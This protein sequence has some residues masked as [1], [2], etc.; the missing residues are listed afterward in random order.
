MKVSPENEDEDVEHGQTPSFRSKTGE[1]RD[2]KISKMSVLTINV[3]S[4]GK[5]GDSETQEE[6]K[7]NEGPKPRL[8][9]I[10]ELT[11]ETANALS[12]QLFA[13]SLLMKLMWFL[14]YSA[15]IYVYILQTM[16][17]L[18]DYN[19][20]PV[21]VS[22]YLRTDAV[23]LE[24]P[25]VTICNN[26]IVRKTSLSR[27]KYLQD[28]AWLDDFSRQTL[29]DKHYKDDYGP[30]ECDWGNQ[31]ECRNGR[32]IPNAW[33]CN[34][35]SECGDGSDENLKHDGCEFYPSRNISESTC[36][37]GYALC[38]GEVTCART[39]D[40]VAD[41]VVERGYDERNE[42]GC[43]ASCVREIIVSEKIE[44][45]TLP[46]YPKN[47][48]ADSNCKYT[49]YAPVGFI[50]EIKFTKFEV[51]KSS[52]CLN[53]WVSLRDSSG[54][55][56]EVDGNY[57]FC[58]S[59]KE[60]G[61]AGKKITSTASSLKVHFISDSFENAL[62]FEIEYRAINSRKRRSFF[63][64]TTLYPPETTRDIPPEEP[65]GFPPGYNSTAASTFW[66]YSS[67]ST[68]WYD[69]S[70]SST[71]QSPIFEENL[72]PNGDSDSQV[73][74]IDTG[75]VFEEVRQYDWYSA[76]QQSAMPDYSDF[77]AFIT[78]NAS[79]I[80]GNGHQVEDFIVQCVIDGQLCSY[81]DFK[82]SQYAEF[83]NCFSI[84]T[85]VDAYSNKTNLEPYRT[86]KT[87]TEH[88][89]K[90]SL[91][92]DK[93][94]YIGIIGQNSGAR[95]TISNSD[96]SPPIN[97]KGIFLSAGAA[98]IISMEQEKI[99]K[100]KAPFSNCVE[101]WPAF[102][103]LRENFKKYSYTT[104][105]CNYLCQQVA[106]AKQ[107]NCTLLAFERDFSANDQV[108]SSM[109]QHC[110]LFNNHQYDCVTAVKKD[111]TKNRR[112]CDCPSPCEERRIDAGVS[113]TEWPTEAY[114]THFVSLLKSSPSLRVQRFLAKAR[115]F[116]L[117]GQD[118]EALTEILRKNFARVEIHFATLNYFQIEE[119]PKYTYQDLCGTLGGNL[120]LWL[121]WSIMAL[122]EMIQWMYFCLRILLINDS[123]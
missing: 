31:F 106:I 3:A 113:L 44:K 121:G 92:L 89:L 63:P 42:S 100:Q 34:G 71:E 61:L 5:A 66:Y 105:H 77:K 108:D 75:N 7:E 28:L 6:A 32:C 4:T 41:C 118:V 38:P 58:G 17:T 56:L 36:D 20:H 84:N 81:H 86:T 93:D 73:S 95:L 24:F 67:S 65:L 30:P 25:A 52:M 57:T 90:L 14:V 82:T 39:C 45:L 79:E 112:T 18:S 88:G 119:S 83:G 21:I 26:N 33:V 87:G 9:R 85:A 64:P 60:S 110:N 59:F 43:V 107:C 102:L 53:D 50:V 29:K 116:S 37:Q 10:R 13:P 68:T 96:E 91:F 23:D 97:S 19:S 1:E 48:S 103:E 80:I 27:I 16:Y 55:T 120:G 46:T 70:S 114:A 111:F 123:Q 47:Y 35:R 78:L 72:D 62:G 8:T 15:F 99:L 115:D 101:N 117:G 11:V 2:R 74:F 54:M 94:E 69:Y 12:P 40:N 49:L 109:Q 122:I 98:T 51:Q 104:D 22:V 76:F